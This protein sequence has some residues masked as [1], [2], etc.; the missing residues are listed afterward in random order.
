MNTTLDKPLEWADL[1]KSMK[2]YPHAWTLTTENMYHEML[3]CLPPRAM[4]SNAFLV[5]EADHHNSDGL[6]V[7]ACF[8]QSPRGVFATYLTVAE[9]KQGVRP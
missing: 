1:W 2:E 5:G 7:Y 4:G 6:P 8:A 3:E 9:F